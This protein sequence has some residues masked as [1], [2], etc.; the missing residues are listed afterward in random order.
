MTCSLFFLFWVPFSAKFCKKK[1]QTSMFSR[2]LQQGSEPG[3][4]KT[5]PRGR[6]KRFPTVPEKISL[7]TFG[8]FLGSFLGYLFGFRGTYL[9]WKTKNIWKFKQRIFVPTWCWW[10]FGRKSFE[11]M[12]FCF[13]RQPWSE[14]CLY[15]LHRY[16]WAR[17]ATRNRFSLTDSI[18]KRRAA[19]FIYDISPAI[20]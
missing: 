5:A 13:S 16:W 2:P 15:R 17:L 1:H 19:D 9:P 6:P 3:T 8:S 18:F 14:L 4:L 10:L 11:Q 20:N 12:S 7:N